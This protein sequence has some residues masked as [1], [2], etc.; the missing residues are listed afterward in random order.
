LLCEGDGLLEKSVQFVDGKCVGL[1]NDV[2]RYP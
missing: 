2:R 1:E